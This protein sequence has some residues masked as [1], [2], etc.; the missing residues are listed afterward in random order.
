MEENPICLFIRDR[1]LELGLTQQQ[2]AEELGITDKAVSKW[3]RGLCCPDITLLRALAETLGVSV[4]E[5]LAGRREEQTVP[6]PPAVEDVVLDTVSYAEAARRKNSGWRFWLFVA[7]TA[8][9]LIAALVLLIVH[10]AAGSGGCLLAVK[11]VAFGW[12]LCCPL[13]CSP[14]PVRGFLVILSLTVIPFLW[15]FIPW[16]YLWAYGIA[17]LSVGCLWAAYAICLRLRYRP[18][19]AAGWSLLLGTVLALVINQIVWGVTG[20][21]PESTGGASTALSGVVCFGIC[22]LMDLIL[23]RRR[24]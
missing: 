5:L 7:V 13:L 14:R 23:Q 24:A 15:Q 3:E 8:G 17:L 18:W 11:C 4:S 2:L 10:F 16:Q 19:L 9:C 1:R 6:I 12:A 21:S 20:A 22:F